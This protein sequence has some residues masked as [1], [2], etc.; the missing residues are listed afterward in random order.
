MDAHAWAEA[1]DG[2]RNRWVIV[3]ATA[4]QDLAGASAAEQSGH[5]G[6]GFGN[7]LSQLLDALYWYGLFGPLRWL[8]GFNKLF[9]SLLALTAL[10]GGILWLFVLRRYF[11]K[12]SQ[13]QIRPSAARNPELVALHKMLARMDRKIKAA[14]LRRDLGETLHAFSIRLRALEEPHVKRGAKYLAPGC[15]G[16]SAPGDGLWVRISDWYLEYA[17]LRYSRTVGSQSGYVSALR[18]DERL[19]QLR[20]A[21]DAC[22]NPARHH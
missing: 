1:W 11:R 8:F 3:E 9:A 20:S 7:T 6:G 16:G 4:Q 12:K 19:Q 17:N 22:K 21:L 14:G 10:F 2:E 13:R 5:L 18:R 15:T